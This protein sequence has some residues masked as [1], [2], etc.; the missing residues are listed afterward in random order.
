MSSSRRYWRS[1]VA[2][3]ARPHPGHA[4]QA[5]RSVADEREQVGDL[6]GVDPEPLHDAGGV[7]HPSADPVEHHDAVALDALGEVVVR[8]TDHDLLD[9][10]LAGVPVRRGGDELV[11]LVAPCRPDDDAEGTHDR[12]GQ[13]LLSTDQRL[14]G[15]GPSCARAR[16]RDDAVEGHRHMCDVGLVEQRGQGREQTAGRTDLSATGT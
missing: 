10:R 11:G 8:R 2:A 4:R 6:A 15:A 7:R 13:R 3:E 5:V 16:R 14:G 12:R 9:R 1:T